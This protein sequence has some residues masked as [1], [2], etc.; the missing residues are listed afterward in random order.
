MKE[1]LLLGRSSLAWQ[2]SLPKLQEN[3]T[4]PK[5]TTL[6]TKMKRKACSSLKKQTASSQTFKDV[7]EFSLLSIFLVLFLWRCWLVFF[8]SFYTLLETDPKV[9]SNVK[10]YACTLC[11]H[12]QNF[13]DAH[14]LGRILF[15]RKVPLEL[16]WKKSMLNKCSL[17]TADRYG[18]ADRPSLLRILCKGHVIK[19]LRIRLGNINLRKG[20]D[21][22]SRFIPRRCWTK[23]VIQTLKNISDRWKSRGTDCSL[24][25][26]IKKNT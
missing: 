11:F 8:L 21:G 20:Q 25:C 12:R 2:W 5:V 3:N 6:T 10:Y 16:F 4:L 9:I 13:Y 19:V 1:Y 22:P 26:I 23:K 24:P 15:H 17:G 18:D 14:S 7:N